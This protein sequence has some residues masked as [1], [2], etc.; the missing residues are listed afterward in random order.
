MD[1]SERGPRMRIEESTSAKRMWA[2]AIVWED[3]LLLAKSWKRIPRAEEGR[4]LKKKRQGARDGS[5]NRLHER[6]D[7]WRLASGSAE[8]Q[9]YD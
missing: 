7:K 8:M 1:R 9:G 5:C 6:R 3:V 2:V 4:V